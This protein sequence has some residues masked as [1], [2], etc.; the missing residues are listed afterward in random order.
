MNF[1]GE[2]KL[3]VNQLQMKFFFSDIPCMKLIS[4]LNNMNFHVIVSITRKAKII[5]VGSFNI[6]LKCIWA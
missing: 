6:H 5:L 1:N 3:Y 2:E 4:F